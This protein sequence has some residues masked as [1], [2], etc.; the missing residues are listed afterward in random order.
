MN[1]N[2]SAHRLVNILE[3]AIE[4]AGDEKDTTAVIGKAMGVENTSNRYFMTDFFVLISDV[5]RS[6]SHLKNVSKKAQYIN[7]VREIQDIFFSHY[8]AAS[9]WPDIRGAIQSR[10]LIMVLDACATFISTEN[11]LISLDEAQLEEYLLKCEEL[12]KEVAASELSKDLKTF[13]IVRLEE[14][15]TAIRHYSIGGSE[16]LRTVVEANIG[17]M[18]LRSAGISPKDREEPILKTLFSWFLTFGSLLGMVTDSQSLLQS[19]FV[20]QFFLPPSK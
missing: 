10:N 19:T 15:C 7:A 13:L 16:R 5:E 14:V 2:N 6:I 20:T 8:L 4:I 18:I 9:H 17:G 3:K 12:L 11:P 1:Q